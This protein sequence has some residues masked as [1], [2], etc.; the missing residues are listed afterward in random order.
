[1]SKLDHLAIPVASYADSKAWYVGVL[2]LHVEF[3][4]P[5]RKMVAVRDDSDLTVFLGEGEVPAHPGAFMLYFSVD[6]VPRSTARAP[7]PVWRSCMS[8][9]LWSGASARN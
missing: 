2:G 5:D 7:K 8:P 3:D 4:V 9:S 1:M 6:D